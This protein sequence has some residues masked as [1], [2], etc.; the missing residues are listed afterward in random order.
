MYFL[1]RNETGRFAICFAIIVAIL[2][3]YL[4]HARYSVVIITFVCVHIAWSLPSLWH[5]E[6]YFRNSLMFMLQPHLC[7]HLLRHYYR[8]QRSWG[9]VMFLQASVILLTGGVCYPSMHC[10]LLLWPSVVV[11]FWLKAAFWYGLLGVGAEG[12]NRRPPH[13]KAITVA[14]WRPPPPPDGYCCGRYA[15]YW[16]AFLF[17][18]WK[19]FIHRNGIS[20]D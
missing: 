15:S 12:H 10:M 6:K 20:S 7:Y 8:P 4:H 5:V 2:C 18:R 16:N 19:Y 3:H 11:T 9:K 1:L 14:W 17:R 13:Q